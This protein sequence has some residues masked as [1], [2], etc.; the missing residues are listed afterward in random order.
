MTESPLVI[1]VANDIVPG[2]G[3]PVAA[4]G[5]RVFGLKS[6]LESLGYA[7]RTVLV[8][9]TLD[10][11]WRAPVP[12]P[13]A[14]GVVPLSGRDLAPYLQTHGPAVVV[15]TNSNQIDNLPLPDEDPNSY[16]IDFFAPKLLELIYQG[17]HGAP[18]PAEQVAALRARM[19]RAIERADGFIV[20]GAKKMPY[21]LAWLLQTSKDPRHLP[22]EQVGMCLPASF[23]DEYAA[24]PSG[25]VRFVMAGYLQGWSVPGSWLRSLG[26]HLASG[27]CTLDAMLPRHWGAAP[28]F[29]NSE[30]S[31]LVE[32]HAINI[33]E[34]QPYGRFT[35][36]LAERDVVLD[37]FD[38]TLERELAVVTRTVVALSCGKPVVHPP[39]TEVAPLIEEFDAG[40]LVDPADEERLR[41]TLESIVDHPEPIAQKALNARELWRQRLDPALAAQGLVRVIRQLPLRAPLVR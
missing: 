35:S 11:Q 16:V 28:R 6:G 34:A 1:L 4:P 26:P 37:L 12:P 5:L 23:Q 22:L 31:A 3:L 29:A 24:S 38:R 40:W 15:L 20:N 7:V 41:S 17:G 14:K 32:Q 25:P 10:R 9:T 39:F 27:R 8:R 30:L 18:Y 13:A 19:L 21:F 33:F 36:F 2:C